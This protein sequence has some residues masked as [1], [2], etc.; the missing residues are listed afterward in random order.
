MSSHSTILLLGLSAICFTRQANA[1]TATTKSAESKSAESKSAEP[2]SAE[3]PKSAEAKSAEPK[4]AESKSAEPDRITPEHSFFTH[5]D[6][7]PPFSVGGVRAELGKDA[8]FRF[9]GFMQTRYLLNNHTADG[10]EGE[11]SN[12]F[13]IA[14]ARVFAEGR[15]APWVSF[16]LRAGATSNGTLQVEQAYADFSH[17]EFAVRV[18]QWYLPLFQEQVPSPDVTLTVNPSAVGG[19]FD[20]GQVLGLRALWT[21]EHWRLQAST[22]DGLRTAFSEVG[23]PA[24]A[25]F[26]FSGRAELVLGE[27]DFGRFATGS[28]FRGERAAVL[29]GVAA[30]YQE[31]GS[32]N[33]VGARVGIGAA[34][35]TLEGDG[36]NLHQSI[37]IADTG[38][39]SHP[40]LGL[41]GQGG[42]FLLPW[43]ELYGRY[44]VLFSSSSSAGGGLF[45]GLTGGVNQYIWPA[46]G[47]RLSV[48]Y[49][50]YFDG[51]VGTPIAA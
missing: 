3:P 43:T 38:M 24:K 19:V 14:R 1:E 50:Y 29:L 5:T 22:I 51:T 2:K 4:S 37:A 46:R 10:G 35:V 30:H 34:D 23:S 42:Y 9:R 15:F 27:P 7:L 45:R 12:G 41:V 32:L 44:E 13:N 40:S 18:G 48:D 21:H 16:L 36:F 17:G 6:G 26:A 11:T 39:A 25:D 8:W 31:G 33:Q 28:S 47:L 49:V 20:G